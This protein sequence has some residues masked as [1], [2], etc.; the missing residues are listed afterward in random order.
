MNIRPVPLAW[1]LLFAAILGRTAAGQTRH[2]AEKIPPP[3]VPTVL[4]IDANDPAYVRIAKNL[5]NWEKQDEKSIREILRKGRA[6]LKEFDKMSQTYGQTPLEQRNQLDRQ[7]RECGSHLGQLKVLS[8]Y[9]QSHGE[10]LKNPASRVDP[11]TAEFISRR[12]DSVEREAE[13]V[14]HMSTQIAQTDYYKQAAV[15]AGEDV[16]EETDPLL[17]ATNSPKQAADAKRVQ[18]QIGLLRAEAEV[19][20]HLRQPEPRQGVP[21]PEFPKICTEL[22]QIKAR[23]P[24]VGASGEGP[25]RSRLGQ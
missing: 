13:A 20:K 1:V 7:L 4:T 18:H 11:L 19:L 25:G 24:D 14:V 21:R 2:S 15:E 16:S 12:A 17:A 22:A 10:A 3:P 23:P 8:D 9:L 5:Y 6:T